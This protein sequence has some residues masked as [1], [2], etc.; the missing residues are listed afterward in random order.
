MKR[1]PILLL[2]T[3]ALL[4][5]LVV[6]AVVLGAPFPGTIAL[7][8]GFAPEGIATGRGTTFYAGSL[9][10]AGIWRGDYRTGEGALLVEGGGP[11]VGMTV[12]AHNR[13]WVAGGPAGTG[14]VFDASTG[15][16]ISTFSFS[17]A[18]T[19]VND[20]V[21]T[22][23]AA[24]FTDS[25]RPAI[26]RVPLGTGGGIGAPSTIALDPSAIGFVA[27]AFNLNGIEATP[28]GDTLI[29]VN[30]TAGAL[31][32][33]DASSG[34]VAEVDLGGASVGN[35]DGILLHGQTLYV[36]RNQLNV[37]AVVELSSDLGHGTVV[38]EVSVD[39]FDVPTTIARFG[40]SLYAVNARFGTPVTP[41]TE[42]WISGLDRS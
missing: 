22:R 39:G 36:V 8:N 17:T 42:Y 9:S 15:A 7:P 20:V 35:G 5:S 25:M 3:A 28:S 2:A 41:D 27:G 13:L 24:Y 1:R 19:F 34:A 30:S 23:D 37:V 4:L 38:D 29:V 40:S 31:F 16:A 18:P 12:D 14:F 21:V 32:S 33:V 6:P 26:Y 10:G 11:F